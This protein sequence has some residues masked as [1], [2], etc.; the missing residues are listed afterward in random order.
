MSAFSPI[1][2]SLWLHKVCEANFAR[3][4]QLIPGLE[5]VGEPDVLVLVE[6]EAE[7]AGRVSGPQHRMHVLLHLAGSRVEPP[8][9]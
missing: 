3:L 8:A 7:R 1:E 9:P 2:K 6:P 4:N 5:H